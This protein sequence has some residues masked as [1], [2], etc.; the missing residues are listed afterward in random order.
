VPSGV[1]PI[2]ADLLVSHIG[3][4]IVDCRLLIIDC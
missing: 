2:T 3:I 1:A 4:A